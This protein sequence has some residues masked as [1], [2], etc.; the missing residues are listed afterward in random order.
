MKIFT[1]MVASK[2]MRGHPKV[3]ELTDF[4]R[5]IQTGDKIHTVRQNYN[6]WLSRVTE[7]NADKAKLELR[8]WS[9]KPYNSDQVT[10]GTL[11]K[12]GIQGFVTNGRGLFSV[13]G[14]VIDPAVL[15]K[16]DGLSPMEFLDWF[17][18]PIPNGAIIHFTDF[19][20]GPQ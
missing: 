3:G 1:I 16:N 2:F 7:V 10:F 19:R 4:R 15:A 20:Y 12:V 6:H 13:D 11:F 5:K 17:T 14:V 8:Q 9:G 18:Y